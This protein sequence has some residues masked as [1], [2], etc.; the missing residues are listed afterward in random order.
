MTKKR[1]KNFANSIYN[2]NIC[3]LK[4]LVKKGHNSKIT[5]FKSYAPCLATAHLQLCKV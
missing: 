1:D 3:L 2:N 4:F 5:A